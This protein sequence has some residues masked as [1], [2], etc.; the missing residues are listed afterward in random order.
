M[1]DTTQEIIC[2]NTAERCNTVFT[3]SSQDIESTLQVTT[4][5]HKLIDTGKYAYGLGFW[6]YSR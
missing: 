2:V 1:E 5:L 4:K 6:V 3:P